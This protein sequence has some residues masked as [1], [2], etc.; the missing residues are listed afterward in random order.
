[1]IVAAGL[2]P[3]W[4]QIL[5]FDHFQLGEV[6]RAA[7]ALWCGSGKVLNVGMALATLSVPSETISP[8][9]GLAREPIERE[10]AAAGA[11]CRWIRTAGA[12]RVC[13]TILDSHGGTTTEL[14]EN[15][16]ALSADEL[17]QFADAYR[18]AVAG[19]DAVVLTG[20]LT[21]GTPTTFYRD[22]LAV[23]SLP[24]V[25]D[26]RGPELL[27]AL[28]GRPLVVKPNREE[29]G[30]T[31]GIEL[32]TDRDVADAI[33]RLHALGAQWV[34]MTQGRGA[35]WVASPQAIER[36]EPP[37]VERVVN[38]IGCGDCLAA[39]IAWGVADGCSVPDAVARGMAAAAQNL[40]QLLPSRLDRAGVLQQ[41]QQI[42]AQ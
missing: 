26:A 28:D 42:C 18:R 41:A 24:T 6:N 23:R 25:L 35:V 21:A 14:V 10:F 40:G 11:K 30:R 19:A 17:R 27:A 4:Q 32:T 33:A 5:R 37:A 1:V 20:S 3:A 16:A 2:T 9:G 36:L 38:P 34:V 15:A 8:L 29:L 22:L 31:L 13:T 7:E 39:G 12:T